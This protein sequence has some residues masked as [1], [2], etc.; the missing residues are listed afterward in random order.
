MHDEEYEAVLFPLA[1]PVDVSRAIAVDYDD[2]DLRPDAP[3]P[4]VYRLPDAPIKD[5]TFWTRVERD[6]VDH[7]VQSRTVD[8]HAN[9][10]SSCSAGP[11]ESADAFAD[12]VPARRPTI[13]PTARSPSLRDKYADKVTKLQ[14]QLQAAEDRAEVLDTERKGRRNEELLSTAGSILGGLLGGRE[15]VAGCSGRSSARPAP[16][17]AGADA[18]RRPATASRR[19]RTRSK[20]CTANSKTS[21]PSWPRR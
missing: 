8:L 6:L 12:T 4:C 21:R 13:W 17:R 19:R 9:R 7:L 14:T 18:R 10:D 1:E 5:K 20:A 3:A 15:A 2:R 11:G 16:L